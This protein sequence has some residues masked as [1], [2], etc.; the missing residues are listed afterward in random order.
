MQRQVVLISLTCST[1]NVAG[2]DL[3]TDCDSNGSTNPRSVSFFSVTRQRQFQPFSS[4]WIVV[5]EKLFAYSSYY[6]VVQLVYTRGRFR[7][8]GG[9]RIGG[10]NWDPRLGTQLRIHRGRS[11]GRLAEVV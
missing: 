10:A 5:A 6:V 11:V 7:G 9:A 2:D 4:Q 8:R 1:F 3:V